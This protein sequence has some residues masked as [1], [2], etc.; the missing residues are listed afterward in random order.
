[1]SRASDLLQAR[2]EG[3]V[4]RFGPELYAVCLRRLGGRRVLAEELIHD[5][6]VVAWQKLPQFEGDD[7]GARRW[8]HRIAYLLTPAVWRRN[9]SLPELTPE[10]LEQH[11]QEPP[12]PVADPS[13][14]GH[15]KHCLGE[16]EPL[17]STLLKLRFGLCSDPAMLDEGP[18]LSWA[19]VAS[20]V[21]A[22]TG[23]PFQP[24]QGRMRATRA[25]KKLKLCL[26]QQQCQAEG[27]PL[28]QQEV[29]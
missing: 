14:V 7:E 10:Q 6:Y 13:D 12:E 15:L 11:R 26:Q 22:Q 9:P 24:D 17:D 23:K 5:T 8:L 3:W 18:E 2:F 4:A 16:L 28:P 29:R 19:E 20:T 1:M 21:S 25:M 27:M